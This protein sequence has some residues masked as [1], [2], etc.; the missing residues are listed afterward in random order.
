MKQPRKVFLAVA[1][2]VV[3]ITSFW[4]GRLT[5]ARRADTPTFSRR[6]G[7]SAPSGQRL[8]TGRPSAMAGSK[9]IVGQIEK[10]D[11]NQLVINVPDGGTRLVMLSASTS[12]SRIASATAADLIAGVNAAVSGTEEGGLVIA[13]TIQIGTMEPKQ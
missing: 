9:M 4:L 10:I 1:I 2:V 3:A 12:V 11:G 6:L 8:M 7:G 13:K 5:V